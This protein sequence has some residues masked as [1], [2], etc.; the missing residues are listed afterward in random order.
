MN[1]SIKSKKTVENIQQKPSSKSLSAKQIVKRHMEDKN[2]LI[3]ED[4]M[5]NVKI[6][7]SLPSEDDPLLFPLETERP[8]DAVKDKETTTPWDIINE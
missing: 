1:K 6:D 3:T 7:S 4:D 5:K 2:A 8:K